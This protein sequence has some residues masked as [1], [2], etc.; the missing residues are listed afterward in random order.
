MV[1]CEN[2]YPGIVR[3]LLEHGADVNEKCDV[4]PAQNFVS[5]MRFVIAFP[6]AQYTPF[7]TI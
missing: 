6:Y 2:G 5:R 7:R 1:S 3:V 4:S